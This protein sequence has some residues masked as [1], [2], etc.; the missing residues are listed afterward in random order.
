[1]ELRQLKYF[2]TAAETLNFSEASKHLCITQSTLS[3]QIASLEHELDQQLFQRNSHE[4]LLTEAGETLLPLAQQT[5][6]DAEICNIRVQELSCLVSGELNI[7]VTYS[8][9]S[10]AAETIMDFLKQYPNVKMNVYYRTMDALMEELLHHKLDFVL[11]FRPFRHD[12]RIESRMLFTSRLAAIVNDNHPL[13]RKKTV[14]LEE[15]SRYNLALPLHGMQ[16]RNAFDKLVEHSNIP[17][18]IKAEMGNIGILFRII[19]ESNYVTVL[20]ESTLIDESGLVA[21]PID[22]AE[23]EMVGCVH[24]LKNSYV[25]HSA[26]EFLQRLVKSLSLYH[27]SFMSEI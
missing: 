20:S 1:M 19:R 9:S 2:V 25:K 5:L 21:V 10:I 24:L 22:E 27:I 12:H 13:A 14:T 17:L 26:R 15:L 8:F 4:M 7:G 11:A 3:Q 18:K 6:R 23:S 16:A